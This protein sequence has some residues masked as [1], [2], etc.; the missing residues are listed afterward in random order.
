MT[1]DILYAFYIIFS[2][3]GSKNDPKNTNI[4]KKK[5][6]HFAENFGKMFW[7]YFLKFSAKIFSFLVKKQLILQDFWKIKN[8]T[9]K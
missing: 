3:S 1:Q 7:T 6:W 8:K 9:K 2:I 5:I 4:L